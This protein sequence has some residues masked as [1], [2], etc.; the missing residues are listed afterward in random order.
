MSAST[1]GE[2]S[3]KRGSPSRPTPSARRGWVNVDFSGERAPRRSGTII[4][5]LIIAVIV[6]LGITAL[7]IDLIRIRYAM[8]TATETENRLIEE[9]RALIARKRQF[10]DPVALAV[11]A[12][13]RGFRSPDTAHSIP[14][15]A[16]AATRM[17]NVAAGPRHERTQ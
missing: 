5:L 8:A 13:E 3:K 15:P 16:L 4:P 6:A 11:E 12:R 2:R 1:W 10:R 14:D 7:R 9:Q 17:P